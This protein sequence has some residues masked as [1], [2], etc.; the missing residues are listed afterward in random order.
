MNKNMDTMNI[1]KWL[2][3]FMLLAAVLPV[4][5][6]KESNNWLFGKHAGLTWNTTRSYLGTDVFGVSGGNLTLY[7]IPTTISSSMSTG[8]GCFSVSDYDGRLLFYSDGITIWN[9]NGT[10]MPNGTGLAGHPSSAQS[11]IIFPYPGATSDKYIAVALGERDANNLSYSIVDMTLNGGLGDVVT[12]QKNIPLTGH[13]GLLGESV[14]AVPHS[15]RRDFW[16]VAGS[17]TTTATY[18]NVWKV[19]TQGVHASAQ[20]SRTINYANEPTSPNGYLKFNNTGTVFFWPQYHGAPS[21]SSYIYIYGEFNPDNGTFTSVKTR[22]ASTS[23]TGASMSSYGVEFSPNQQYVYITRI[24]G[25]YNET[26][27]SNSNLFI[28]NVSQLLSAANPNTVSPLLSF[29]SPSPAAPHD[30]T[31][32]HF[33]AIGLSP[34]DRMYIK[35]SYSNSLFVI[36]NPDNPGNLRFWHLNGVLGSFATVGG[37]G[38]GWGLPSSTAFYFHMNVISSAESAGGTPCSG[39]SSAYQLIVSGGKGGEFLRYF[40]INWG[41]GSAHTINS[42]PQINTTYN[43]NHT[44]PSD[45]T[46]TITI[47]CYDKTEEDILYTYTRTIVVGTCL[48]PVNPNVRVGF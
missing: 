8:E 29:E 5:A 2:L 14:T 47:I 37:Q 28:F 15:N 18:L 27:N 1:R 30:G 7:N 25:S 17:R 11:G 42:N 22:N 3:V 24:S 41:D 23:S 9:R 19:D 36:T 21:V 16:I 34:D 43:Y 10:P 13:L 26:T 40:H 32:R 31:H 6:Q 46:Y 12:G 39:Q 48:L 20:S 45:G 38:G 33:G 35:D 4:A 44:Y